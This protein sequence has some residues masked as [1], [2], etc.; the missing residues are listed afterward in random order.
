MSTLRPPGTDTYQLV[1]KATAQSVVEVWEAFARAQT[2]G[3]VTLLDSLPQDLAG[4]QLKKAA[5]AEQFYVSRFKALTL[6]PVP[7][8]SDLS[9][10]PLSDS[11]R[12]LNRP[13]FFRDHIRRRV[14]NSATLFAGTLQPFALP[15]NGTYA[16]IGGRYLFSPTGCR[17]K[18]HYD[19]A[20]TIDRWYGFSASF[21]RGF[22]F[23]NSTFSQSDKIA[24]HLTQAQVG[25]YHKADIWVTNDRYVSC[26][27]YVE[28]GG[29][30][31]NGKLQPVIS[32]MAR[33]ELFPLLLSIR[34]SYP[35]SLVLPLRLLLPLSVTYAYQ[36]SPK[37]A[38]QRLLSVEIDL[39]F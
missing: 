3:Q 5:A 9:R 36:F 23:G 18:D 11:I 24:S 37:Q 19:K 2:N 10:Y 13:L 33:L 25:V 21:T 15:N 16:I 14:A 27:V 22:Q 26:H 39:T 38:N 7:Y 31:Y 35:K 8:G 20:G 17:Y 34:K 6:M 1:V 4:R 29:A 30:W 12:Q 28:A 32:P